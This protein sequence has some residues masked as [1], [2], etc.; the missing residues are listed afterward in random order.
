MQHHSTRRA[1]LAGMSATTLALPAM[2]RARNLIGPAFNSLGDLGAAKGIRFGSAVSSGVGTPFLDETQHGRPP[3]GGLRDPRVTAAMLRECAI[4]VPTNELKMYTIQPKEGVY[5]FEPGDEFVAFFQQNNLPVR[6]HTLVWAKDEFAPKWL[7]AHD[8]G[9]NPKLAAEK[10]LRDYIAKVTSRYQGKLVS[11]DV[12]N[13]A[14][15]EKTGKVR[16]NVFTRILGRDMLRIAFEAARETLPGIELVYNDYMSWDADKDRLHRQGAVELLRWFRDANIPVDALGIQSHIGA[17]DNP[18][19]AWEAEWRRFLADVSAMDYRLLVTEFDVNDRFVQGSIAER[20]AAV[21]RATRSY[22]DATL[23]NKA[24]RDVLC[25]GLDDKYS[26]LQNT[27]G[28]TDKLPLRPTPY[29]SEFRPKA[30]RDAIAA[31]LMAAST[32]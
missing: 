15:D 29:D 16:D 32:R 9:K 12:V 27:T 18:G 3:G 2:A 21:V 26:W 19:G 25:W 28:R 13:E 23:E 8:F 22:L 10:L 14:I 7:L 20:D 24:T 5:T 4:V 6:G 11:W 30:M 17:T 31:S 1:V